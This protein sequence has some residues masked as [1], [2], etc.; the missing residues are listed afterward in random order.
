MPI[1]YVGDDSHEGGLVIEAYRSRMTVQDP[2]DLPAYTYAEAGRILEMPPSTLRAWSR[3]QAYRV[4]DRQHWFSSVLELPDAFDSR[5]SYHNLIEAY[6]L[7][8]LRTVHQLALDEVREA[9]RVAAEE[10]GIERL[11]I[12]EDMRA[13]AGE[14]FLERYGSLISL[15]RGQQ[16]AMERILRDYLWRVDYDEQGLAMAFYPLTRGPRATDSPKIIVLN[17]RISFGR[18]VIERQGIRTSAIYS[19]INAGEAPGHIAHDY[20]LTQAEVEEALIFE[21][22]A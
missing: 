17:P 12:H 3:G 10:F 18:P 22:A 15:G 8:A 20:G 16:L 19:R 13:S 14:V 6:A 7:R 21:A 4:K 2:R 11:L 1:A 5:F 9:V